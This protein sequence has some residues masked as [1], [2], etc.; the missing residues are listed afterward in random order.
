VNRKV[1]IVISAFSCLLYIG[2]GSRRR[3]NRV[4]SEEDGGRLA[5]ERVIYWS[6]FV[7]LSKAELV[8]GVFA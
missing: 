3:K 5:I 1:F 7:Q 4:A 6:L 2:N 8:V